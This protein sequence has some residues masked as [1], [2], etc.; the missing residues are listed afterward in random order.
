MLDLS[1][2][3]IAKNESKMRICSSISLFHY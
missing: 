2:H 1:K 3:K